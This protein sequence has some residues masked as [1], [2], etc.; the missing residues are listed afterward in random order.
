MVTYDH[1]DF[2]ERNCFINIYFIALMLNEATW[3]KYPYSSDDL[4]SDHRA[5]VLRKGNFSWTVAIRCYQPIAPSWSEPLFHKRRRIVFLSIGRKTEIY[6]QNEKL[7]RKKLKETGFM[8]LE[9]HVFR[10]CPNKSFQMYFVNKFGRDCVFELEFVFISLSIST[11]SVRNDKMTTR[12]AEYNFF[13]IFYFTCR[14][15]SLFFN[16][17][18]FVG[19][20]SKMNHRE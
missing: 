2:F 18:N 9:K 8:S 6:N 15:Q 5:E 4:T 20:K 11:M 13:K 3:K 1:S 12:C 19:Y 14:N 16:F 17:I 10:H 7:Y